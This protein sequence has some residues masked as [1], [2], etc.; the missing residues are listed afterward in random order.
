MSTPDDVPDYDAD[1]DLELQPD[2]AAFDRYA[3]ELKA[4]AE[5]FG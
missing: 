4:A 2:D 5:A 3:S 1:E